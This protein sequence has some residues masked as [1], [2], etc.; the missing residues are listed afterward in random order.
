LANRTL[1]EVDF[2]TMFNAGVVG[3]RRGGKR[4][5][6]QL[7]RIPLKV[8]DSLLLAVGNDF[9]Q[10]R[11]LDRNFHLLSGSLQRPRLDRRQSTLAL[12]GFASA[13]LCAAFGWLSLF[14]ALLC[15]LG[16]LLASGLLNAHELRRRF[17]FELLLVIGSALTIAQGMQTSGAAQLV[18]HTLQTLFNGHGVYAAFIGIFIMTVLL[19]ETVTNN[20]AA[21]LAFPIALSTAHTFGADPM[22]FILAVAYGA[23][24]CFLIPF[25]YQTHLMVYS[26]GR[27]RLQDFIHT[28]LPVS[29]IYSAA[30]LILTPMLF[31]FSP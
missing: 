9:R 3:I 22:P 26:P 4:L 30:V 7:G 25:G 16:A 21:A 23:S 24:A 28:G 14:E 8:G 6:G 2:R 11:N 12:G 10:H 31:P 5:K 18:A 15:L 13:I 29:L 27:Y 17:P 20:A 1:Q 19:T